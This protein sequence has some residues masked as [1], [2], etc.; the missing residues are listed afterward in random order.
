MYE[1]EDSLLGERIALKTVLSNIADDE[2]AVARLKYEVQT[3]R[4]VT[5]GNVCRIFDVGIHEFEGAESTPPESVA[6]ITMELLVGETLAARLARTGRLSLRE[7][8]PLLEQVATGLDA[9]HEVGVIHR[10]LKSDNIMLVSAGTG[11]LRAVIMDFGLARSAIATRPVQVSYGSR[12]ML[13]TVGY[14]APEQVEGKAVTAAADIY[15]FGIVTYEMLTGTLPFQGT[16]ALATAVKR[17]RTAPPPLSKTVADIEPRCETVVARCLA[18]E[19]SERFLTARDVVGAL[20]GVSSSTAPAA[21]GRAGT[22]GK[23][24][25]A[26]SAVAAIVA[27]MVWQKGDSPRTPDRSPASAPPAEAPA[28]RHSNAPP[29][30][31]NTVKIPPPVVEAAPARARSR[32]NSKRS[33]TKVARS[34]SSP[35]APP[36]RATETKQHE[37]GLPADQEA[38]DAIIDP[39]QAR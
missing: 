6:F 12:A 30:E 4:R 18:I 11:R 33:K 28:P 24:S 19:P 22:V 13:G 17:L 34:S 3:A 15:A 9:A 14:M 29:E 5:N 31:S 25:V 16:T 20:A 23:W 7:S 38:D 1:V 39:F 21:N 27:S 35:D 2:R 32:N 36:T 10:D 8:L 26:V 37:K